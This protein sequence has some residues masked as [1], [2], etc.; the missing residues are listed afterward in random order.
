MRKENIDRIARS[1]TNNWN[2]LSQKSPF[3]EIDL[4][5]A[6]NDALV[7]TSSQIKI[8]EFHGFNHQVVFA[9]KDNWSRKIGRCEISDLLIVIFSRKPQPYARMTFIQA[10]RS[11][12]NFNLCNGYPQHQNVVKFDA[13]LE[14]WDLLK[15][16]PFI[17]GYPPFDPPPGLLNGAILSS[18][19]SFII[20]NMKNSGE[21]SFFYTTADALIP[22]GNPSKR[23]A[24]LVS[25]AGNCDRQI[26]VFNEKRIACCPYIFSEALFS[27]MIG[28]PIDYLNITNRE[29]EEYRRSTRKWLSRSLIVSMEQVQK[30]YPVA[31]QL[32]TFLET[33]NDD[34]DRTSYTLPS[35]TLIIN[36]DDLNNEEKY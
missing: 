30:E 8:D 14:Q 28:T 33:T 10:K 12:G 26:G 3:L 5:R 1:F 9:G 31:R 35:R 18:V 7:N 29:D 13:N 32:L 17:I 16:R 15:R 6:L 34:F 21:K 24:K 25:I 27:G 20:F 23:N 22:Y 11:Q 2:G 36:T 4:F 19:G